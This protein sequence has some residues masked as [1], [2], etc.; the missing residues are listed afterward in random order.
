MDEPGAKGLT[1]MAKIAVV[2]IAGLL[3]LG[4]FRNGISLENWRRFWSNLIERPEGPMSFRFV[5][6]PVMAS[7]AALKDGIKDARTGRSPYFWTIL[8]NPEK[9]T[10]RLNEGLISTAQIL[11]LGLVMDCIYQYKVFDTFYPG[12]AVNVALIL[13]FIPYLLLRGPIARIARHWVAPS[14]RG[15]AVS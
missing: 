13:A 7:I 8:S 3:L 14:A 5:L 2:L 15:S 1:M 10:A 6:Q 12:E 4:L 11:V 9:R